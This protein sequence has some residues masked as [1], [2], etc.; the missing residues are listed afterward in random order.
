M[1]LLPTND[2][3]REILG[4]K[5]PIPLGWQ[6][7]VETYN[8]GENFVNQ[9]G[10]KSVFE[11]PDVSKER[12]RY[13]MGVGRI[14]MMGSSAFRGPKFDL[15][16]IKPEVGDYV[17]FQRYEGVFKTHA[18]KDVQYLQDYLIMDIIPDPSLCSY[19]HFIGN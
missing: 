4:D 1:R 9:D 16:D 14:L 2:L 17:S 11:R 15:W 7:L 10:S 19:L 13:Q 12:D 3:I 5:H 6:V 18:G 8:F